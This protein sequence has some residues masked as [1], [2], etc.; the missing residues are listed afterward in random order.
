MAEIARYQRSEAAQAV[1]T[2]KAEANNLQSLAERLRQFSERQHDREDRQAAIEGEQAGQLAGSGKIGGLDLSDNSTIRSRAFNKGA[3]LSHA[4]AIK[5]DINENISRL[6]LENPYDVAAFNEKA[7]GYKKGLLSKVDSS[8]YALAE[9]DLN[10]AISNGTIRIGEDFMKMEQKNQVATIQ[11]GVAVA[12]E[13]ILQL[14]AAGDIE[15]AEDQ[16][17]QVLTALQEGVALNL[18]GLDQAF[19]DDYMLKLSELSDSELILGTFKRELEANGIEAAQTALD[20]FSA[21]TDTLIDDEGNEVSIRPDTKRK[22]ITSM[23]TLINRE[24]ADQNAIDS[25]EKAKLAATKK[26]LKD[27]VTQHIKALDL[28]QFPDT[29]EELKKQL[30]QFPELETDLLRAESE[31]AAAA[32]FMKASPGTM[33]LVI[34]DMNAKKDLSP[35]K[36]QLLERY[37]K[38]FADT[39][40]RMETDM[41]N[42]AVEQGIISE[43]PNINFADPDSIKDRVLQYRTAQAHYG[44]SGGSPLTAFETKTLVDRLSDTETGSWE[45]MALLTN[46]VDGF[47]PASTDLFE[48]MFGESAPEYI[49]VGE[50]ISEGRS[51]GAQGPLSTGE[52]ILQGMELINKDLVVVESDLENNIL[53]H[54][55]DAARENPDYAQMVVQ[56]VKALYVNANRGN[57][58]DTVDMEKQ[59]KKYLE[60]VTGGVLEINGSNI[61]APKRGITEKMFETR[62]ENLTRND[63]NAMGGVDLSRYTAAEALELVQDGRF[64]SVGQGQYVVIINEG[65]PE[66]QLRNKF[67]ETFIFNF[68]TTHGIKDSWSEDGFSVDYKKIEAEAEVKKQV[69]KEEEKEK[70]TTIEEQKEL[71]DP[72][73]KIGLFT[74]PDDEE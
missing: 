54:F 39:T 31:A 33:E 30:V 58:G 48:G 49:M 35:A 28:N 7:A 25:A 5:I 20:A 8:L 62:V 40:A 16:M 47:G 65:P 6:K 72:D 73:Q 9:A 60:E 18:P 23:N 19:V 46:L 17:A 10:T 53:L 34:S 21:Y 69:K 42:L 32:V 70:I 55:G 52:K 44:V 38:I 13:L 24:Q 68:D 63:L 41:L 51:T 2:S 71:I 59:I 11:K 4:A 26:V 64:V 3:Q 45:K 27:Q 74:V 14:S 61:I 22:I 36:A 57:T 1:P 66:E 29:L 67:Y 15:G 43:L 56:S 37:K 50:L 12:E